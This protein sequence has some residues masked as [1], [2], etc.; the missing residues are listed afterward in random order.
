VQS[1]GPAIAGK[2]S[3][4]VKFFDEA[5]NEDKP[6]VVSCVFTEQNFDVFQF[7]KYSEQNQ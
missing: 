1:I 4:P 2:Y 7:Q 5:N 3:K 6:A